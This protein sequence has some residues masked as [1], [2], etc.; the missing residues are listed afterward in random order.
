MPLGS[1]DAD[2]A[3][4][5]PTPA[6]QAGIADSVVTAA[7]LLPLCPPSIKRAH[8][9]RGPTGDGSL[10][11]PR[12][13]L[14]QVSGFQHPKTAYVLLGLQVRPVG[15]EHLAIG[16]RPQ[17]LRAAG[18][19][20]ATNENPDTGSHHLV[21]ERVDIAGHRFGLCG[22]VVVVG[23][24]N[25]NQILRHD[26]SYSCNGLLLVT[27]LGRAG[28]PAFTIWSNRRTG[29]RQIV[30]ELFL[31]PRF[32]TMLCAWSSQYP[33]RLLIY[34]N[35]R[36]RSCRNCRSGSCWVSARAFS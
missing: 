35:C 34:F 33:H 10:A 30:Q 27:A 9:D 1:R 28:C 4:G 21:V 17:R 25:S 20:E 18:R 13:C 22:R 12:K 32:G 3:R 6:R 31:L 2:P 19:G 11:P 23:V 26:F 7:Q 24:V 8:L 5:T 15:D 14:V 16:L 29:I 36:I